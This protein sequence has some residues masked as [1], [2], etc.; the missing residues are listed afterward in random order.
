MYLFLKRMSISFSIDFQHDNAEM[1]IIIP[2]GSCNEVALIATSAFCGV[3][4]G[5]GFI[6]YLQFL[7]VCEHIGNRCVHLVDGKV[8]AVNRVGGQKQFLVDDD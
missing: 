1:T 6:T 3:R 2:F 8:F 5:F 4:V 7:P